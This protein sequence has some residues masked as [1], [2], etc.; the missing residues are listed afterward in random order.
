MPKKLTPSFSQALPELVKEWD[1]TKNSLS[2]KEISC[3]S[4]IAVWFICSK[5][6]SFKSSPVSRLKGA[7]CRKCGTSERALKKRRE[8]PLTKKYPKIF[9]DWDYSK[10]TLRPEEIGKADKREIWWTCK[11]KH[12][13]VVSFFS[14]ARS[15]GCKI[16]SKP[17]KAKNISKARSKKGLSFAETQSHLLSQW[18]YEKNDVTPEELSEKSSYK[19]WFKCSKNHEWRSTPKRRSRG[20]GCP[21]CYELLDKSKL[22]REQKLR[23]KGVSLEEE[24]PELVQEWDFDRNKEL[25]ESFS[26]GSNSKVF[27]K[28]KFGHSWKT[29]IYNRTGNQSNCPYCN[30]STSKLEIYILTEMRMLFKE[31]NW[32]Y[33]IDG[34]E[35]DIYIPEIKTGIE[36][37]GAYWH[38]DKLERDRLKL[39]VF[40]GRGVRLLRVRD[41]SLPTIEGDVVLYNKRSEYIKLSIEVVEYILQNKK[42]V[43]LSEY[44]EQK[45]QL[46][47]KEYRRILSLL[48]AP[49]EENSLGEKN[50]QLSEEWDYDKNAPLTPFMFTANSEKKVF[51][52]CNEGHSWEASIKNRNARN[53]GCPLCYKEN[54]GELIRK[55]ILDKRGVSFGDKFPKLLEQWNYD[56]NDRSPFEISPGSS[57]KVHWKCEAGHYWEAVVGSRT[58][59]GDGCPEC[60]NL[61]RGEKLRKSLLLKGGVSFKDKF[62]QLLKEWDYEKNEKSPEDYS[63]HSKVKVYWKCKNGHS[64][65][66]TLASRAKGIGNCQV[67]SSIIITNPDLLKEWDYAKN[68]DFSPEEL[69]VGSSKKVWWI[70]PKHGSYKLSVYDKVNGVNCLA[71]SKT[72][73]IE[74]Y[75]QKILEKRGSLFSNR[76]ELM[77]YWDYDKNSEIADPRKITVGCYTEVWWKCENGH[78]WLSKIATMTDKRKKKS[79]KFCV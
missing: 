37:D 14:R 30:S 35:C 77:K 11:E 44:I 41:D 54:A 57:L 6:H 53:S 46:G 42:S 7:K 18:N 49:T 33:K 65:I 22:V 10:N 48:P 40:E 66:A 58:K 29:S 72:K 51:W 5:G 73:K 19:V 55:A 64:W 31:V 60:Y 8:E 68:K 69:S 39:N 15:Q 63:P 70:C 26:S 79:C 61:N 20:D 38:D 28:C 74:S 27:W 59:R 1:N 32:R 34:F 4:K 76:P 9:E 17:E 43:L 62:P 12:S 67:C 52:K 3:K 25:P 2:P 36:V 45:R 75:Q 16:C 13:Y 24:Y 50:V 21:K 23:K 56:L 71:C 47:I 78:S